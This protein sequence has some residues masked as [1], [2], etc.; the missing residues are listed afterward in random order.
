MTI[1]VEL[2]GLFPVVRP[3]VRRASAWLHLAL[4]W[5]VNALA[6][7]LLAWAAAPVAAALYAGA[8]LVVTFVAPVWLMSVQRYKNVLGGAWQ[9]ARVGTGS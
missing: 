9:E 7:A 1:A 5:A 6:V 2:F 4:A 3:H 8:L